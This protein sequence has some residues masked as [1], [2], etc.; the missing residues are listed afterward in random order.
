[1]SIREWW[2]KL[3]KET[4]EEAEKKREGAKGK[5]EKAEESFKYPNRFVKFYHLNKEKLNKERRGSYTSR[6][7][8]GVCVRC[9]RKVVPG[10]VFCEYHQEK[11]KEY[12][13][14]A[15]SK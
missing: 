13:K 3:K 10:I 7:K 14:K 6:R 5:E 15:R 1:M 11:Q 8:D 4:K 9:K 2:N 12:N